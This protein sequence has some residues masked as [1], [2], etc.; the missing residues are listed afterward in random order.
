MDEHILRRQFRNNAEILLV[1]GVSPGE[2]VKDKD[3]L[4]LQVG[5]RLGE[6]GVVLFLFNG[7]IHVAPR[8]FV[9]HGGRIHDEL[10]LGAAPGVLAGIDD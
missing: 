6:N 3:F 10:V 2:A 4:A 5:F 9:M 8:D 7:H 1:F